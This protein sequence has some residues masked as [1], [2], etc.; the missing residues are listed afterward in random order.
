MRVDCTLYKF[1]LLVGL[2][3]KLKRLC[4]L[5]KSAIRLDKSAIEK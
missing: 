1:M 5:Y 3:Q 4:R 2:M